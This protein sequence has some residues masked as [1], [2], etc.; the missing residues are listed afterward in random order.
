MSQDNRDAPMTQG[1]FQTL[2]DMMQRQLNKMDNFE[3]DLNQVKRDV[4][5]LQTDMAEVKEDV[6]QLKE[7]VSTIKSVYNLPDTPP[8]ENKRQ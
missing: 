4:R 6:S 7:D 2:R 3:N 5:H 8:S 1:Q